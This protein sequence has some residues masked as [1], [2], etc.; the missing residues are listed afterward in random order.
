MILEEAEDTVPFTTTDVPSVI[1]GT[2]VPPEMLK[3]SDAVVLS[4]AETVNF[5]FTTGKFVVVALVAKT[6]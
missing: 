4:F 3:V 6:L 1:F 5:C 2:L